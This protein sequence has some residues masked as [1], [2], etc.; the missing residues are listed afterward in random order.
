M[1]G[2]SQAGT[3]NNFGPSYASQDP[4]ATSRNAASTATDKAQD[5]VS[6]VKEKASSLPSML[7]DRLQSG[8][9][10]LRQGR[11]PS[12]A[13]ANGA[14]DGTMA[15]DRPMDQ[16]SDKLATGMQASADWLRDADLRK[17]QDGLE[18]QVKY[19]PGR[20]LLIALGVGYMLGK[21]IRR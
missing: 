7:A 19:R 5:M 20:T 15:S 4:A 18:Q 17:L 8:A 12:M 3:P 11:G 6:N 9:E 10:A 2:N 16:V 21:A 1:E 13:T 14:N